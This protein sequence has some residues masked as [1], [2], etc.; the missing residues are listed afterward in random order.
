ME[1]ASH[2]MMWLVPRM[3]LGRACGVASGQ[4]HLVCGGG[5]VSVALRVVATLIYFPMYDCVPLTLNRGSLTTLART[6]TTNEGWTT[7]FFLNV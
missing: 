2:K 7:W 3:L 1:V 5:V 4:L 6:C